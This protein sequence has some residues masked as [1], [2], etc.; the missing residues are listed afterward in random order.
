MGGYQISPTKE[1][2]YVHRAGYAVAHGLFH[3]KL[4]SNSDK[5]IV[6]SF[7]AVNNSVSDCKWHSENSNKTTF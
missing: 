7:D 2:I 4:K 1:Y 5:P 3:S 6:I